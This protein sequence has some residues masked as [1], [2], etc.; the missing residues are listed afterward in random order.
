MTLGSHPTISPATREDLPVVLEL[1]RQCDLLETGVA[2]A[3]DRFCIASTASGLVGC[4]GLETYG[5]LGLLRSVAVDASARGTG[6]GTRLVE[7]VVSAARERGLRDLFLLTT[8]AAP[9]FERRGFA[10]VRRSS[11]PAEI[12]ASWEF[13]VGCPQ[14]ATIQRLVLDRPPNQQRVP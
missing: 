2:E 11:V 1:L 4:A 6:V 8:T 5:E 9:F 12:A 10:S 14:T 7:A 3:I 13:R